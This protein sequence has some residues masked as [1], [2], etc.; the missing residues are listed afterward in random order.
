MTAIRPALADDAPRLQ[1]I[2]LATHGQ[3]SVIGYD[4]VANDPPDSVEVLYDYAEAGR[5]WVAVSD[6]G[7]VIGYILLDGAGHVEQVTVHPAH[8]GSGVGKALIEQA[9]IWALSRGCRVLTLTTFS[10]VP[11]NR[12]LY[13]HLGFRVLADDEVGPELR[14]VQAHEAEKG[15]GP[16]GRVAMRLQLLG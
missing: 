15:F 9:K 1:A 6:N 8:Q 10:E 5:S 13:E 11:W 14:S 7:D 2:E 4:H 12:P 3:F 16:A